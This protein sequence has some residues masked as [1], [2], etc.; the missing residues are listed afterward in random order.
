MISYRKA[1]LFERHKE[2]NSPIGK[3]Y[4]TV[5]YAIGY[6]N[7]TNDVV[8]KIEGGDVWTSRTG[9]TTPSL[10]D[11]T[12]LGVRHGIALFSN[13]Y[14]KNLIGKGV[15]LWAGKDNSQKYVGKIVSMDDGIIKTDTG[16]KV[17]LLEYGWDQKHQVGYHPKRD[18]GHRVEE[19]SG[20]FN[21]D[22]YDHIT[23]TQI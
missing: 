14:F 9:F 19:E 6:P 10:T 15:F 5:P 2:A 17:D 18:W 8:T 11:T 7:A 21:R 23:L 1:D 20:L 12:F 16:E 13:P 3:P 22:K 4:R